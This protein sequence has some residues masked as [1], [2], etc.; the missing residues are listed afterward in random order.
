MQ[1]LRSIWTTHSTRIW[2]YI[3]HKTGLNKFSRFK[4]FIVCFVIKTVEQK[5]DTKGYLSDSTY[6]KLK[7]GKSN[8]W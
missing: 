8:L 3:G 5:S 6:M 1:Q 7:T 2:I 4:H